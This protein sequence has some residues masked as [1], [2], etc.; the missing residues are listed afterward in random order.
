M[1]SSEQL[2]EF[3]GKV[4]VVVMAKAFMNLLLMH[5]DNIN[6]AGGLSGER[7]KC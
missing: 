5:S 6:Y 7:R 1:A 4:R 2:V 3:S